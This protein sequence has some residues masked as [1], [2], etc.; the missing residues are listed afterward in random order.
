[1][2]CFG[3]GG[4][5]LLGCLMILFVCVCLTCW[6]VMG[7]CVVILLLFGGLYCLLFNVPDFML[8]VGCVYLCVAA[9]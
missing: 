4:Y 9:C 6:F 1:M 5:G 2:L 7:I 3:F 8:L